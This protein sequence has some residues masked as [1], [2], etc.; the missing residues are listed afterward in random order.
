[1]PV[2][3]EPL[4]APA[5]YRSDRLFAY[6]RLAGD[7]TYDNA[8]TELAAAGHPVIQ[9]DLA[10]AYDV[11]AEFFRWEFATAIAGYWLAINPFDQPNVESAKIVA[12]AMVAAYAL[13]NFGA[14]R[15]RRR[16][17]TGCAVGDGCR[18]ARLCFDPCLYCA[19]A[20]C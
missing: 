1:L 17:H 9:L 19:V 11:A 16:R 15:R 10:D 13:H 3:L 8:V 6:L 4:G 5:A 12:R 18:R 14:G 20:C 2:D 7:A